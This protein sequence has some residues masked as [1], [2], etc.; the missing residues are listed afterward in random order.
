MSQGGPAITSAGA[1]KQ[2][3]AGPSIPRGWGWS[4]IRPTQ[5]CFIPSFQLAS[6][7]CSSVSSLSGLGSS[8]ESKPGRGWGVGH[9]ASPG[10]YR[11]TLELLFKMP[12]SA[13]ASPEK[14]CLLF[15]TTQ[16]NHKN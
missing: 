5:V 3:G 13:P 12:A 11:K 1:N 15:L 4:S 6:A 9:L 16:R 8:W 10:R 14:V 7:F 2:A